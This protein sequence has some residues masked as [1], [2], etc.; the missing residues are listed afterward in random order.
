VAWRENNSLKERFTVKSHFTLNALYI[1]RLAQTRK[2][3]GNQ[4]MQKTTFCIIKGHILQCN[5]PSFA[6]QKAAFCS[7]NQCVSGRKQQ[8]YA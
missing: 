4:T 8:K 1:K 6:T 2:Y 5:K 3:A 7:A